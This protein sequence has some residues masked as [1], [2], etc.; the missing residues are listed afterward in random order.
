MT[1]ISAIWVGNA[2]AR[3]EIVATVG[4]VSVSPGAMNV[5]PGK[6][7]LWIDLRGTNRA[8]MDQ[9]QEA[10]RLSAEALAAS[11]GTPVTFN[12]LSADDPVPMTPKIVTLLTDVARDLNIPTMP[13]ISGAGHDTMN[14]ADIADVG[15]IFIRCK[16]GLSHN[17]GEFAATDDIMAGADILTEALLRLA[18]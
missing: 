17:P 8:V 11:Y 9:A 13:I 14:M 5:V 16:D 3:R 7:E 1:R 18:V 4:N 15:M 2:F 12:Q 6:A 10:L